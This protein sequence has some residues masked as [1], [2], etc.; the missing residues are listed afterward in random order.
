M[1][2]IDLERNKSLLNLAS[3]LKAQDAFPFKYLKYRFK[4]ISQ[5]CPPKDRHD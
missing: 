3:Y 5:V 2:F 4:K 1:K